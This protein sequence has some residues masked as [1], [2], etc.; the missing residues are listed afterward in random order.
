V[1]RA[2]LLD[3]GPLVA[4]L[5]SRDQHHEWAVS[6]IG[7]LDGPLHTCEAVVSEACFLL[8]RYRGG[9]GAVLQLIERDLVRIS[10]RLEAE[11]ERVRKLL[12]RYDKVPISFADA[13]LVRM[14]EMMSDCLLLTVDADFLVY[15]RNGRQAI[16]VLMPPH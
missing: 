9:S 8:R 14:T 11:P 3:T 10:F 15:R 2:Y 5:N 1:T 4:L 13:C 16:P 7:D 6:C 12:A